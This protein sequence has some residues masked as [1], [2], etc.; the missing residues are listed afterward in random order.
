MDNDCHLQEQI[1]E[2]INMKYKKISL[3]EALEI[4]IAGD[5]LYVAF[6]NGDIVDSCH[7]YISINNY[8]YVKLKT[9]TILC[10]KIKG[11]TVK[12][13]YLTEQYAADNA[14]DNNDYE[15]IAREFV[16]VIPND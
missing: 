15:Y 4:K 2:E 3:Q 8:Y 6:N 7:E 11:A 5:E 10:N 9:E 1:Q 16:E 14:T 13:G 12:Q